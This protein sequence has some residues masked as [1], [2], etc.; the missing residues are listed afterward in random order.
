MITP[1]PYQ[2]D[3]I[4]RASARYASGIKS[5][6]VQAPVGSGKTIV[7]SEIVR[8]AV[9][10]GKRVLFLAHRRRLITQKADKLTA[11]GVPHAILMSGHAQQT[12]CPVQVA[13]RDTLLSRAVRND[14]I[15][16]PPADLVIVDEAHRVLGDEY[17][18]LLAM[19]PDAWHL[20]MTA[21][22]A[23]GDGRGLGAFYQALECC[24]GIKELIAG[25]YIVPV[26]CYAP[27]N[28]DA[29]RR[30]L[31]GDPVATWQRLAAGRPTVL[32]TSRVAESQAVCAAFNAAGVSAEHMD[33]NT[34]DETRDA[35]AARV[36][37]GL[38]QVVCNCDVLTEGVDIPCLSC[39]ILL[40]L[41]GSYVLFIQ[42]IGR[43]MRSHP[44]K[45]DAILIDHADAVLEH[46]FPDEDVR[47]ELDPDDTVDRR[48]RQDKKD[49]KRSKP[50]ICPK[51]GFEFRAAIVCPQCGYHLPKRLQPPS[52]RAQI[53][54]EVERALSPEERHER[55]VRY[56]HECLRVMAHKGYTVGAAAGMF[57]GRYPEGPDDSL[58]NFP[59]GCQWRQSVRDAFPQYL[60]KGVANA[61]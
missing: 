6:L 41:A 59:A 42:A 48:N 44:G 23:R 32:F 14:W 34:D 21:T 12:S 2:M 30:K 52:L 47:W 39:C 43:T 18:R 4:E 9:A 35:I 37:A 26:K 13:S 46:G 22:P 60:T 49:G 19:Y 55:K 3:L 54:T 31:G 36:E 10:R 56:W 28:K 57:R 33:G 50:I 45:S 29:A 51:C 58:P 16:P 7:S 40:R 1:R 61:G 8:R 25:G 27:Q 20:G 53:L 11:F 38:T 24:V 5:L 15:N 17:Q